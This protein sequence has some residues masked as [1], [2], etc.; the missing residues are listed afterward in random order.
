MRV[1]AWWQKFVTGLPV[2]HNLYQNNIL[3]NQKPYQILGSDA[4]VNRLIVEGAKVDRAYGQVKGKNTSSI[5]VQHFAK[6][7]QEDSSY[8]IHYST[9]GE[10]NQ[11]QDYQK[12]PKHNEGKS[13]NRTDYQLPDYQKNPKHNEGKSYEI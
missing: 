6:V 13:K 10:L 3:T 1:P 5:R 2:Y 4:E 7:P 11:I 8:D 12:N 9:E